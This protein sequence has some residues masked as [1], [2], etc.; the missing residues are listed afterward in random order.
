MVA[1]TDNFAH[2]II[3]PHLPAFIERYPKLNIALQN[4]NRYPDFKREDID[5]FW[6]LNFAGD[7]DV[8]KSKLGSLR[9]VI[10]ATPGLFSPAWYA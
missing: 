9:Y 8:V 1:T 2:D 4:I 6:G 10:V 3:L 7:E 5:L